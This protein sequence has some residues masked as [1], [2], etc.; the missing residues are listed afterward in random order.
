M[1]GESDSFYRFICRKRGC[2]RAGGKKE[3]QREREREEAF[4]ESQVLGSRTVS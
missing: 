4:E 3:G 2:L 1:G